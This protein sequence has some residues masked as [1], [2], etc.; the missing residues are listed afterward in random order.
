MRGTIQ[1]A[2]EHG[3][4]PGKCIRPF[5]PCLAEC[6]HE[7]QRIQKDISFR[8]RQRGLVKRKIRTLKGQEGARS[9]CMPDSRRKAAVSSKMLVLRMAPP[10]GGTRCTRGSGLDQVVLDGK[11]HQ[12]RCRVHACACAAPPRDGSPPSS[13][14]APAPARSPC[15]SALGDQLRDLE[16]ARGEVLQ[17]RFLP[18]MDRRV[19]HQLA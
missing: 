5:S 15:W 19:D 18:V 4:Q 3:R 2:H 13:R 16:L 10:S 12:L 1:A 9:D 8:R 11:A 6:F 7:H 17:R 14:S